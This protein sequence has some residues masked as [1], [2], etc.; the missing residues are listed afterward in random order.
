MYPHALAILPYSVKKGKKESFGGFQRHFVEISQDNQ[1]GN[2]SIFGEKG[3]SKGKKDCF[4]R[5]RWISADFW[6]F[7]RDVIGIIKE[8]FPALLTN[9][10]KNKMEKGKSGGVA[11]RSYRRLAAASAACRARAASPS[12]AAAAGADSA[13]SLN[14]PYARRPAENCVHGRG[15]WLALHVQEAGAGIDEKFGQVRSTSR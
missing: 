8:E 5:F 2:P 4:W 3:K 12:A 10:R 13:T 1:G 14:G 9:K 6:G 15:R 7:H 11:D